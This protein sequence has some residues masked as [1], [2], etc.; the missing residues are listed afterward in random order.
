MTELT[1]SAGII[2]FRKNKNGALEFF[3]GHPGGPFFENIDYWT[4]LK[5]GVKDGED[6]FDAAVREFNEESGVDLSGIASDRFIPLGSVQQ[7]ASKVVA[8]FGLEYPYIK[9]ENCRSNLTE[10]GFPEIN[11]YRWMIYDELKDR[12]HDTHLVFYRT[13][14]DLHED[15]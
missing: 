3:L 15:C 5:G 13:L 10:E 2:P 9:A 12:V 14:T 6:W 11:R 7:N 8:A 4:F 1:F